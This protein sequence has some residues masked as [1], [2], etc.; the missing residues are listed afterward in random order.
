MECL[1]HGYSSLSS[2]F[3]PDWTVEHQL[4]A[5]QHQRLSRI[6]EIF[7]Q[8]HNAPELS[9]GCLDLSVF[10]DQTNMLHFLIMHSH[11]HELAIDV[12]TLPDEKLPISADQ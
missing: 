5:V 3:L 9:N 4:F 6:V 12:G 8:M 1:F 7:D 10:A 2:S 11:Q